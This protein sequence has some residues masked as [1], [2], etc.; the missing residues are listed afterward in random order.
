[1]HSGTAEQVSASESHTKFG[2]Q[3]H[4]GLVEETPMHVF[5]LSSWTKLSAFEMM[6]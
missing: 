2:L 6:R 5:T 4:V 3:K 1:M